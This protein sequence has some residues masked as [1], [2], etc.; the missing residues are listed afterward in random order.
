MS[1][2]TLVFFGAMPIGS[3]LAGTIA[4]QIGEPLTVMLAASILFVLAI[5]VWVFLPAIRRQE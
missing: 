5:G 1:I 4:E 3:L 2:Y